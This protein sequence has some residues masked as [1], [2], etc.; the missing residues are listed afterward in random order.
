MFVKD[1]LTGDSG[2]LAF[3]VYA[4]LEREQNKR[5]EKQKQIVGSEVGAHYPVEVRPARHVRDRKGTK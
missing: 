2:L 3:R 4:V 5:S 1:H